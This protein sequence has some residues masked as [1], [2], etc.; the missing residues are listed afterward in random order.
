LWKTYDH[1]EIQEKMDLHRATGFKVTGV[2]DFYVSP[3]TRC[4]F[5]H[6]K[7]EFEDVAHRFTV[8]Y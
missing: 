4:E 6:E 5:N 8:Y 7:A 2:E 1:Q 3:A